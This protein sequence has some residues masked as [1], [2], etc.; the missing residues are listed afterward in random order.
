[1]TLLDLYGATSLHQDPGYEYCDPM[2]PPNC[3]KGSDLSFCITNKYPAYDIALFV[4]KYADIANQC[5]NDLFDGNTKP[6][7]ESFDYSYY[8]VASKGPSKYDASYWIGPEGYICSS[9]IDYTKITRQ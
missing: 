9:K 7:E 4:K 1:M 6:Q 2:K 5:A 8:T 3:A